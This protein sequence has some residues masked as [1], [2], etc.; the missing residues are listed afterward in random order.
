MG[1]DPGE[2]RVGVAVS[3]P[4]AV[5]AVPVETL[6]RGRRDVERICSIAVERAAVGIF[7]GLPRSMSGAEGAAAV[8]AREFARELAR[9]SPAPVRMLDERL[10]TVTATRELQ[11][12]GRTSRQSRPVVDQ[13]AA[14]V[15]LQAALDQ[16]SSTGSPVGE[17]VS[18]SAEGEQ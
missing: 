18:G 15:L 14:T 3:D 7:V 2:V 17:L 6:A 1:V 10:T 4:E 9:R 16:M 13:V 8:R 12:S 11:A 5:L